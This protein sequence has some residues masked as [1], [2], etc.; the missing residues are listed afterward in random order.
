M[1]SI[2]RHFVSLRGVSRGPSQQDRSFEHTGKPFNFSGFVIELRGGWFLITAGH[3]LEHIGEA[4]RAGMAVENFCLDDAYRPDAKFKQS[5]A[6]I[7]FDFDNAKKHFVDQPDVGDYAAIY[8]S[9][10]YRSLL[11]Q[12]K[13][14][15]FSPKEM[16]VLDSDMHFEAC[17]LIGLPDELMQVVG[18]GE[19]AQHRSQLVIIQAEPI[20]FDDLPVQIRKNI[21]SQG[22]RKDNFFARIPEADE[23]KRGDESGLQNIVG[24]SGG[25]LVGW[26]RRSDGVMGYSVFAVQSRWWETDRIIMACPLTRYIDAL[27]YTIQMALLK[28][29]P[30]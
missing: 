4:R 3:V 7:P 23:L 10:Y 22:Y 11:T 17:W 14:L 28:N 15:P 26:R 13:I 1:N 6:L 9:P 12:N 27:D 29:N 5:A 30:S 16:A 20:Q 2:G 21:E 8:L 24:V 18:K 25:P 19:E